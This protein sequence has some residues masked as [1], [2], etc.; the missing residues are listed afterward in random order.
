MTEICD[1]LII[2]GGIAGA[3]AGYALAAHGKTIVL[4]REDQ[5]GYHSTGRSAAQ[6]TELYGNYVIRSLARLS[7]PFLENP[8]EG[9]TEHKILT[10]RGA[11]F[12]ATEAQRPKLE[13]FAS[14]AESE[15][16][17]VCE[18]DHAAARAMVPVLR[19]DALQC[20]LHEPDS[21]DMDVHA[22]HGGYLRALRE[23]GG[24]VVT[25]AEATAFSRAPGSWSVET[26]GGETYD[27]A[28]VVNAAGAWADA[29]AGLA[30]VRPAG[31]VPKR[32]T[33]ML[34]DP[35]SDLDCGA[36]PLVIDMDEQ[37]YFKPDAGKLL[38]SPADETPIEPCDVQPDELDI[39]IAVDRIQNVSTLKID[40]IDHRWSGLRTFAEDKTPV[41]GFA[42]GAEGF[43]WLAGQGGY[44]I[45]TAPAMSA[46]AAG[47][48][49]D[50][51]LPESFAA[52]DFSPANLAPDRFAS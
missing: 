11:L 28:V 31:L 20:A 34:F 43:F 3:S 25:D 52:F 49:V 29:V 33:A 35:P 39:A 21:T 18:L 13:A 44:G 8:P 32:R 4:E 9:F 27:A 30:G 47:L 19:T 24:S 38:G 17:P 50:G 16:V 14:F 48:I 10:P 46:A 26:R 7:K 40:R 2:G 23:R 51:R 6:F 41:V 12:V 22:L 1:F 37:W 15:S 5:P 45:E 42:R 36:W